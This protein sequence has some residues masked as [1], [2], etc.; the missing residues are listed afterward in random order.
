MTNS[1]AR[2]FTAE[3][4]RAG[5][6]GR[7]LD[8]DTI[9]MEAPAPVAA[10]TDL[11]PV[12]AAISV[13]GG[14]FDK[15]IGVDHQEIERIRTEVSDIAGRIRSTKA[16]IAALRH[17][18]ASDDKLNQASAQLE[19]VVASTEDATN[20]IMAAAEHIDET[21]AEL[22]SH[23]TD[24]YQSDRL[25]DIAD[26]VVRIYESCNFQ[27]LTGQR[28]NKVVKTLAFIEERVNNMMAIWGEAELATLPLPPSL[29]KHDG[30]LDLHGP[31]EVGTAD[32]VS[33]ADIDKL[34]D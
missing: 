11:G 33:Q 18:L 32:S 7:S 23:V 15:V 25:N 5:R 26:H 28:I 2:P 30:G 8:S 16:E 34:F 4:Q 20:N 29:E 6:Q 10:V 1:A 19:A 3:R 14:K 24:S 12:L 21:I 31:A 9:R 17:P 22:R 27:D 13:L